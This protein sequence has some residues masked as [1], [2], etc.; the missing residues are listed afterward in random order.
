MIQW[1]DTAS[2]SVHGPLRLQGPV[3]Y[4]TSHI[5]GWWSS[6][7]T[8]LKYNICIATSPHGYTGKSDIA[9]A[10]RLQQE[11]MHADPCSQSFIITVIDLGYPRL[12]FP[13]Q[14]VHS[15]AG[16]ISMNFLLRN[17]NYPPGHRYA[18]HRYALSKKDC[19]TAASDVCRGSSNPKIRT[20]AV[21]VTSK[22]TPDPR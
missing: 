11:A 17:S 12:I 5:P 20:M 3:V 6:F 8:L 9:V 22:A 4:C 21:L 16:Y 7:P 19:T 1:L 14:Q 13:H 15:A 18:V 2:C 10:L